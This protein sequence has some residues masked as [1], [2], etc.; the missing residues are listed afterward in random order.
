M[1]VR[2][3]RNSNGS[4]SAFGSGSFSEPRAFVAPEQGAA[5]YLLELKDHR[6][7]IADCIGRLE[8]GQLIAEDRSVLIRRCHKLAANSQ[9]NGYPQIGV[10]AASLEK[11][12]L[13]RTNDKALLVL[14]HGL[15]MVCH[16]ALVFLPSE[17]SFRPTS[18]AGHVPLILVVDDDRAVRSVIESLFV[19]HARVVTAAD[20]LAALEMILEERPDMVLLDDT[21]PGMSG[22]RLLDHLK[23]KGLMGNHADHL[24]VVM[25]TS[26]DRPQ[27]IARAFDAGVMDYVLKPFSPVLLAEK[28]WG[29][30]T[31]ENK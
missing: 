5:S 22:L 29:I 19:K 21:M 25:L 12:L 9:L 17:G 26:T 10:A 2:G 18:R 11:A 16:Q 13:E 1:A 14:L 4:H 8:S 3:S 23:E 30:L 7:A 28:I 31:P 27:D 24:Q 20:G 6:P 15:H